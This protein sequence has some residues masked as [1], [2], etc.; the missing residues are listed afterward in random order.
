MIF[1]IVMT[2]LFHLE[3]S[4]FHEHLCNKNKYS[5]SEFL[6][7]ILYR[8]HSNVCE[9]KAFWITIIVHHCFVTMYVFNWVILWFSE[10]SLG[11][12]WYT[13]QSHDYCATVRKLG[14]YIQWLS[15]WYKM[16]R[17]NAILFCLSMY[18]ATDKDLTSITTHVIFWIT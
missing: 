9:I 16:M 5:T 13:I 8:R 6:S 3:I 4:V 7:I 14:N 2:F 18:Y 1:S 12:H 10:I 15:K 17:L 11:W